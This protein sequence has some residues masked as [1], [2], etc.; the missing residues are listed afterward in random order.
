[1]GVLIMKNAAF[2]ESK[3]P[4]LKHNPPRRTMLRFSTYTILSE[5][6]PNGGHALM[7]GCSGAMDV[8]PD[9]LAKLI[10]HVVTESPH[11]EAYV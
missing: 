3:S 2:D 4:S 1:M 9:S 5:P 10:Q 8:V 11:G 6:L 7:N